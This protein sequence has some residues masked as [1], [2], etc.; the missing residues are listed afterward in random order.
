[1]HN[2]RRMH[3]FTYVSSCVKYMIFLLNF[4]IWVGYIHTFFCY[5]YSFVK[6]TC[7]LSHLFCIFVSFIDFKFSLM[8]ET[9][10][11]F[12]FFVIKNIENVYIHKY[13]YFYKLYTYFSCNISHCV[14]IMN[15]EFLMENIEVLELKNKM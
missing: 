14:W 6:N 4:I 7:P 1:M 8:S 11:M 12:I 9:I 5:M 13:Y 2:R 3:N 15:V 10:L